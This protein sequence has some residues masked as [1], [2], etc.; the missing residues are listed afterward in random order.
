MEADNKA[1]LLSSAEKNT[2]A[3]MME[4]YHRIL[5]EPNLSENILFNI[6]VEG[7]RKNVMVEMDYLQDDDSM[8]FHQQLEPYCVKQHAT[9]W[10]LM[11]RKR[12]G[13]FDSFALTNIRDIRLTDLKFQLDYENCVKLCEQIADS[14]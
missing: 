5:L 3:K 6:I 14:F 1:S 10:Y 9:H 2:L 8:L 13:S 4:F 11:G 12:D 7:M